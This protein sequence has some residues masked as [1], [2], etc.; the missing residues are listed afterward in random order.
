MSS[1]SPRRTA[2][3]PR[4]SRG[5]ARVDA[6]VAAGAEVFAEQGFEAATMTEIAA[7]A[8]AS[9]G[10]LY[11]YFPVKDD[12]AAELHG[13]QLDAFAAML[14]SLTDTWSGEPVDRLADRLFAQ[15]LAFLEE[16]PSFA[17]VGNRRSIDPEVKK[18]ARNRLRGLIGN[19][20]SKA[21]PPVP[22]DRLKPLSAVLLHLIRVA[23]QLKTDDDLSIRKTAVDELRAMLKGHLVGLAGPD[24]TASS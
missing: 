21:A 2:R 6:L 23:T 3:V 1:E 19:L 22:Q 20:L 18:A 10:S 16:N 7:R 5:K 4:Q 9:I 11:Q 8:G 17:I 24:A 12:L 14:E 13:R 15:L